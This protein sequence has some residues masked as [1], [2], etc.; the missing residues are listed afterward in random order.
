MCKMR[1]PRSPGVVC[2]WQAEVTGVVAEVG[3]PIGHAGQP[4]TPLQELPRRHTGCTAGTAH[5][6]LLGQEVERADEPLGLR[7]REGGVA[8]QAQGVFTVARRRRRDG[9]EAEENQEAGGRHWSGAEDEEEL[10]V[11]GGSGGWGLERGAVCARI[12]RGVR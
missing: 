12:Y 4:D 10:A 5:A 9:G 8:G 3:D 2:V 11:R 1:R 7:R 6:R